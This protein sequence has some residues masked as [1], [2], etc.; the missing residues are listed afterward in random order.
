MGICLS[1]WTISSE[2]PRLFGRGQWE[3]ACPFGQSVAKIP[4]HK[5]G[6]FLYSYPLGFFDCQFQESAHISLIS[7]S[8]FQPSS[9]SAL[10]AS[11]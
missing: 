4:V 11:E 7:Y 2:N 1:F 3:P 8:A 6:D 9:L 10:E 5:D